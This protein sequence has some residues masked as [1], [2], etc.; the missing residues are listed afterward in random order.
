M[1]RYEY[2]NSNGNL[3]GYQTY[4]SLLRQW[5]YTDLQNNNSQSKYPKREYTNPRSQ[6]DWDFMLKAA[7]IKQEQIEREEQKLAQKEAYERQERINKKERILDN[8]RYA[9]KYPSRVG[10]GWY[11]VIVTDDSQEDF[12][13]ERKVFVNNDAIERYIVDDYWENPVVF[14]SKIDKGHCTV[15]L[16]NRRDDQYGYLH[17]Y[18][19]DYILNP[20]NGYASAPPIPG[21][22]SFWTNHKAAKKGIDIYIDNYYMGELNTYFSK[23]DL[24]GQKHPSSCDQNGTL[25]IKYKPGTYKYEAIGNGVKWSGNITITSNK[26]Y[27]YGLMK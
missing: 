15:R 7:Q 14:S 1:N 13:E 25:K 26:C 24:K 17:V 4:N 16:K 11:K 10:Y 27:L 22:I 2:F 18:F 23:K 20:S 6:Y 5:E 3:I 19:I 12:C 9:S 21:E 8:Y